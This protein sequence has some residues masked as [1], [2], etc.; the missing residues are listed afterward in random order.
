MKA[1]SSRE[2]LRHVPWNV[3][4]FSLRMYL[5]MCGL[6]SGG[7]IQQYGQFIQAAQAHGLITGVFSVGLSVVALSAF[8][9][10]LPA[11]LFAALGL[12][13]THLPVA[14]QTTLSLA[15]VTGAD[16]RPKLTPIGSLAIL[17]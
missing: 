8:M 17:L 13:D 16:I 4:V 5:V 6:R 12:Q 7:W 1:F 15:A 9:N 11:V 10:N 14:A 3:V 2:V